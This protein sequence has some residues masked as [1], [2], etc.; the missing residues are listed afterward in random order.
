ME[1]NK[2]IVKSLKGKGVSQSC[3]RCTSLSFQIV[4]RSEL[5]VGEELLIPT[6]L[7][8]CNKCGFIVLHVEN[9]LLPQIFKDLA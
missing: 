9:V 8:V 2:E 6:I 1:D 7:I 3:P 5:P 4:G